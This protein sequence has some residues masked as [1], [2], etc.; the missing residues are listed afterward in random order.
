MSQ[1]YLPVHK[2][3]Q[4]S[5]R[6]HGAPRRG[7]IMHPDESL[8][9]GHECPSSVCF[10]VPPPPHSMRRTLEDNKLFTLLTLM[11]S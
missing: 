6:S 5:S 1:S 2:Q 3:H 4:S 10:K 9:N 8:L 7:N 11:A